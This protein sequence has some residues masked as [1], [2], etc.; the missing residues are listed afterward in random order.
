MNN[1]IALSLHFKPKHSIF[2]H[3][4]IFLMFDHIEFSYKILMGNFNVVF[5]ICYQINLG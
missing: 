2:N 3:C 4:F 5:I 1:L